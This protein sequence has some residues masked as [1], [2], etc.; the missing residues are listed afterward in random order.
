MTMPIRR[1]AVIGGGVMGSG[2]AAHLANA[3][4][5]V[6]LL[7]VVPPDL[8][9]EEK[10][11]RKARNRFS[12]GGLD[13]ALKAKPAAFFHESFARLVSVGNVE[14]D[15][16]RL[17]DVDLVI[18][19]IIEKVE[20]KRALFEKLQAIVP[21]HAIVASNTSGIRIAAMTEG[22][23]EDFKKRFCVMH[24]FNPVRYMKLLE[25]VAGPKTS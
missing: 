15:L 18:E 22:L 10:G 20:P 1:T 14:D 2:I 24:F 11:Q 7:D 4:V 8:K 16:P 3:G 12:Q 9:P 17:K 5:E 13:K 19:A 6:L 23:S 25:L 21:A